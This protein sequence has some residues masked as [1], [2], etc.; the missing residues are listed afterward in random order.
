M[1]CGTKK[2]IVE[3]E[4]EDKRLF[5]EVAARTPVK[6]RKTVRNVIGQEA[7]I[8]SCRSQSGSIKS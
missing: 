8:L 1:Q 6:A 7:R 3:Y 2:F 4:T 5:K